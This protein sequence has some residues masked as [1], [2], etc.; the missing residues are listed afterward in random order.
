MEEPDEAEEKEEDL[1]S[2]TISFPSVHLHMRNI[3]FQKAAPALSSSLEAVVN[4]E[5]L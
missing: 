4:N 3:Y 1:K 5:M 2:L